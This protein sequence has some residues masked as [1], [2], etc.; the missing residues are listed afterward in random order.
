M[1][2]GKMKI[3]VTESEDFSKQALK[4]LSNIGTVSLLNVQDENVLLE[5]IKEADVLFIRLKFH[6]SQKIIDTAP[7][8][9]YILTAT[10]GL[11]HIDVDYFENKGGN[12]ISLKGENNFLSS[13]P[14]T[15][16]HTWGLLLAL[17][18][19]TSIA[20]E[21]VKKG[22]WRRDLFK[23]SNL[24]EK[25]I[26]LLG[27]GRVGIQV[28]KYAEAFGLEVGFYDIENKS[29]TNYRRFDNPKNLFI[30][31]DIIS[32][33][34]PLNKANIHFVSQQLLDN[35]KN[36]TIL[37]NTSRGAIIDETYLC[38]LIK[39][40]RIGGYAAD[41]LENEIALKSNVEKEKLVLL[42]Q[43]GY[44]VLLTPHIAGATY[45]SMEMTEEFIAEKLY[46]IM[47]KK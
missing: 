12:V 16:E 1:K 32:I 8:L 11:D 25:K 29:D 9:K 42:A 33:H 41:V 18:R 39:M 35:L 27:L 46:K 20:F 23:G 40:N 5:S 15:A 37:I 6:I 3:V 38:H 14:S 2:N 36:S 4:L 44:N 34:I 45:E 10:T 26:G 31:S 24:K 22:Y 7:K 28:A 47:K 19:N 17:M 43:Q 13:I 21:D 30:W